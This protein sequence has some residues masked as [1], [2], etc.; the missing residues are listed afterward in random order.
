MLVEIVIVLFVLIF[1]PFV[2]CFFEMEFRLEDFVDNPLVEMFLRCTKAN[3]LLIAE[4]YKVP[5]VKLSK[6]H[7]IRVELRDALVG[8]NILLQV[9]GVPKSPERVVQAAE[10]IRLKELEVE[11]QHLEVSS[12]Q[13]FI[14]VSWS[15]EWLLRFPLGPRPLM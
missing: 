1:L 14:C 2:V 12:R 7:V 4:Y 8:R 9:Q 13:K 15:L 11:L 6:K 10:G 5:V 3:L